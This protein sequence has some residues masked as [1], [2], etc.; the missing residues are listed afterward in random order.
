LSPSPGPDELA[1]QVGPDVLPEAAGGPDRIL[2]PGTGELLLALFVVVL[3]VIGP[4]VVALPRSPS[5]LCDGGVLWV[6]YDIGLYFYL[7][8][9]VSIQY[10]IY[11]FF[12]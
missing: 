6:G 11:Y 3:T 10:Y 5:P 4:G 7:V 8:L 12:K 1:L 2:A 9:H